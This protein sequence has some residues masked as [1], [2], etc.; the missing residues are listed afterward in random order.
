MHAHATRQRTIADE[1]PIVIRRYR[2]PKCG[3]VVTVLPGFLARNLQQRTATV[4]EVIAPTPARR[5]RVPPRTR[6]RWRARARTAATTAL[7]AL[8]A[9]RSPTLLAVVER[10]GLDGTRGALLDA[11]RPLA[12]PRGPLAALTNLLNL[13]LRGLRV[14]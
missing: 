4:E 8:S 1:L 11:F 7:L 13:A 9:L 3:G 10:V 14:M 6:R 5:S 2:C 12:G